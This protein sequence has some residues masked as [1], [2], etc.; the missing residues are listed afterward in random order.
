[1]ARR[2]CA[3][4]VNEKKHPSGIEDAGDVRVLHEGEGLPLLL[5]AGDDFLRVHAEL[6]DLEGDAPPHGLLLLGHPDGAK[7]AFADL[8]E[9]FVG[10]DAV[11][12]F[13]GF[14]AGEFALDFG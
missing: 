11:A 12:G 10:A 14:E 9:E 4:A 8:L 6:D 7:A 2:F 1:M 5:E 3:I 13:L